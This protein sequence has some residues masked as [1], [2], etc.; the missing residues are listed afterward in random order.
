[1]LKKKLFHRDKLLYFL[2]KKLWSSKKLINFFIDWKLLKIE[3]YRKW[4]IYYSDLMCF[5]NMCENIK[6]LFCETGGVC[7]TYEKQY[8]L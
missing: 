5:L 4:Y 6:N 3:N 1:M 8:T 2:W 7:G